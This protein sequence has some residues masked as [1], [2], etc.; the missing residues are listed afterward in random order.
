MLSSHVTASWGWRTKMLGVF[1]AFISN[2]NAFPHTLA[3]DL[4]S[5]ILRSSHGVLLSLTKTPRGA[6]VKSSWENTNPQY[7]TVQFRAAR[8]LLYERELVNMFQVRSSYISLGRVSD[9]ACSSRQLP[10]QLPANFDRCKKQALLFLHGYIISKHRNDDGLYDLFVREQIF[11]RPQR[12]QS[13]AL[14]KTVEEDDR[15]SLLL[16]LWY[17]SVISAWLVRTRT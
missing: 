15:H 13:T 9:L 5:A 8:L 4:R 7:V 16:R 17:H 6:G 12:V 3:C 1:V 14:S 10:S 11:W 2:L